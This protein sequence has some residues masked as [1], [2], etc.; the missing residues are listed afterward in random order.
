MEDAYL[1]VSSGNGND[2]LSNLPATWIVNQNLP[3]SYRRCRATVYRLLLH[4]KRQ[5]HLYSIVNIRCDTL[6]KHHRLHTLI[7]VQRNHPIQRSLMFWVHSRV[8]GRIIILA[9]TQGRYLACSDDI[10]MIQIRCIARSAPCYERDLAAGKP[11]RDVGEGRTI[12]A[13][14][15]TVATTLLKREPE[16]VAQL[17][18]IFCR[19]SKRKIGG[20]VGQHLV[21]MRAA[22]LGQS[23]VGAKR[24]KGHDDSPSLP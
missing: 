12:D 14:F 18:P 7:C 3:E 5:D 20:L 24:A 2:Y 23:D 21:E 9:I 10:D 1:A 6:A 4:A 16:E 11:L 17:T 15:S 8:C 19:L 13:I 22:H